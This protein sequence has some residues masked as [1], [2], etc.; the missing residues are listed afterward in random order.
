MTIR[1]V[2]IGTARVVVGLPLVVIVI[3][4]ASI[5]VLDQTN[6]TIIS[7]GQKREYLLYVPKSYDLTK[8]TSL[9]ISMHGAAGWPAQQMNLS[10][11]NRL[12]DENGFIVVYPSG[13]GVPKIWHVDRSRPHARCPVHFRVDRHIAGGV[14]HR[15]DEDLC[16]RAF[17]WRRHGVC[18]FLHA[19]RSG[20]GGRDGSG[21][22]VTTVELVYGQATGADDCVSWGR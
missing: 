20:R 9:V 10:Q 2:L 8:A 1:K 21:R 14:Q 12:A 4:A 17:H 22:A 15:P 13:S 5:Y 19:V 7:S 18:A 16:Q 6:G 3:A 11:W